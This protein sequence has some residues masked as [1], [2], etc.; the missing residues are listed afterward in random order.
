MSGHYS[1]RPY[2]SGSNLDLTYQQLY[3]KLEEFPPDYQPL[4]ALERARSQQLAPIASGRPGF[5]N[6]NFDNLVDIETQA[7]WNQMRNPIALKTVHKIAA[8]DYVL[9]Y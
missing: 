5:L 3:Q 9:D 8:E 1:P 2:D 6:T 4:V 7:K